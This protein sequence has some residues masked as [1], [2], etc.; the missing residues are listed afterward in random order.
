MTIEYYKKNVYGKEVL[1][2]KDSEQARL[3]TKIT[4]KKT[5]DDIDL[6]T[7][8]KLGVTFVQVMN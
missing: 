5:I 8:Y 2:I 3:V 6:V 7:F 1:Y 4:G